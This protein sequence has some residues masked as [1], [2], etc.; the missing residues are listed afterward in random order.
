MSYSPVILN[1]IQALCAMPGIGRKSAQ[2]IAFHLLEKDREGAQT[3]SMSLSQA[4]LKIRNCE[5]CRML[6][7]DSL[8]TI[9]SSGSRDE[10]T[11]CIV[12]SPS[13]VMAIEDATG[14]KGKYFILM[15]HLSPI[16]GVGPEELGLSKLE[17]KLAK[18]VISELIIATN[19][20]VE[21]DATAHLLSGI[22]AKYRISCSRI[23]HGIP[24]GG[25]LEYVDGGTISHAF[26]GRRKME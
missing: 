11:I 26:F 19:S 9:C 16:D 13:D 17:N 21:G 1:L 7:D 5:E 22:A 24:L 23:A 20:T 18:G 8:C 14:F 15:G 6:T 4:A 25:E 3:L 2:R 12:E 10:S